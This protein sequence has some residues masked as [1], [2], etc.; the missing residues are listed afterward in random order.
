MRHIGGSRAVRTVRKAVAT[1]RPVCRQQRPLA[2]SRPR[3]PRSQGGRRRTPH[4]TTPHARAAAALMAA[5]L[6]AAALAAAVVL[7]GAVAA[8]AAAALAVWWCPS[9]A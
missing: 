6:A 9:L 2:P 1:R 3:H 8:A 5:V 7:A 4:R